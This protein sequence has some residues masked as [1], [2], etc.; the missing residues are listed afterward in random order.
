MLTV[1]VHIWGTKYGPDY[2]ARLASGVH[3]HLK[4]PHRFVAISDRAE[5][6]P[7]T[8]ERIELE[9]RALTDVK[10]C[11][12]RL[13]MFDPEWQRRHGMTGRIVSLDLDDIITGPLDPLFDRPENFVIFQGANAANPCPYN[14]SVFMVR[15]GAHPEVWKDFSIAAAQSIPRHDFPDDQGWLWH[16]IPNAAGWKAGPQ[17]GV[18]GFQKPGWPKGTALPPDARLVAFFGW[19]DPSKFI[20]LDW[21]KKN[22]AA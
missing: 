14:G 9:D 16:K 18:Y 1:A 6:V 8:I 21:V 4:Q 20:Q 2:V 15:A 3:R 17:S 10:G 12:V 5:L 22:W 11:F 19:R 13:K 7:P